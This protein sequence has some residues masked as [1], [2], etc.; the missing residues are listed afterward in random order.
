MQEREQV[1]PITNVFTINE[2][3]KVIINNPMV[4][5]TTML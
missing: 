3:V 1:M 5:S 2:K 4:V